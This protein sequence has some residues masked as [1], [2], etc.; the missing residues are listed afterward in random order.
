MPKSARIEVKSEVG[1]AVKGL[2]DVEKA[3]DKVGKKAEATSNGI[4]KM[5]GAMDVLASTQIGG[6]IGSFAAD[7]GRMGIACI[8]SAA[9]MNSTK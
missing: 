3:L 1:G 4:G 9:K 5:S 6:M 7:I 8:Q 2:E